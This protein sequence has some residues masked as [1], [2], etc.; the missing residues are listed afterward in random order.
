MRLP[1][2]NREGKLALYSWSLNL[3]NH[4][5]LLKPTSEGVVGS[6]WIL[7]SGGPTRALKL[8]RLLHW[9]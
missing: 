5:S 4:V 1:G 6:L 7:Q 9:G 2:E 8:E 3:G